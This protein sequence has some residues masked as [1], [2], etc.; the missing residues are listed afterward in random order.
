M[1]DLQCP[2]LIKFAAW[3]VETIH[4]A[5]RGPLA[6]IVLPRATEHGPIHTLYSPAH[7]KLKFPD[8]DW[9]FLTHVAANCA[10][11]FHTIHERSHVIGDVNQGN[12]LVSARGTVFLIDCDSFQ[13]T[14][15]GK[16]FPCEVG[17][18]HFTPPELAGHNLREHP[19]AQPR[20]LRPGSAHFSLIVSG[21]A[22]LRRT[23]PRPGRHADQARSTNIA[24]PLAARPPNCKCCG[25]RTRC[26]WTIA[27]RWRGYTH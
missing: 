10:A 2:E 13:V 25:R 18:A 21:A 3:P 15:E 11:A 12:V 7:R 24:S 6:G 5:P 19:H 22:S 26:H 14:T 17:V 16:V 23:L 8:K 27:P 9:A 1:V 4:A 20:L